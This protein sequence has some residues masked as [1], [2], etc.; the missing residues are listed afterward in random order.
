MAIDKEQTSSKRTQAK[1]PKFETTLMIPSLEDTQKVK[2]LN[3]YDYIKDNKIVIEEAKFSIA[4]ITRKFGVKKTE[5]VTYLK[6]VCDLS[7]KLGTNEVCEVLF[8]IKNKLEKEQISKKR[9]SV[10]DVAFQLALE[11]DRLKHIVINPIT[12]TPI[13]KAPTMNLEQDDV[14]I[15]KTENE[16][17]KVLPLVSIDTSKDSYV[18]VDENELIDENRHASLINQAIIRDDADYE[19]EEPKGEEIIEDLVI[20]LPET[21]KKKEKPFKKIILMS[22][23]ASIIVLGL[24]GTFMFITSGGDVKGKNN[25]PNNI[26]VVAPIPQ[27]QDNQGVAMNNTTLIAPDNSVKNDENVIVQKPLTIAPVQIPKPQEVVSST[28]NIETDL[29]VNNM[30]N[31]QQETPEQTNKKLDRLIEER[32]EKILNERAK[33]EEIKKPTL[34]NKVESNFQPQQIETEQP[35]KSFTIED[36][37]IQSIKDFGNIME[38]IK[39]TDGKALI[40]KGVEIVE[41]D[42]LGNIQIQ[43]IIPNVSV[44]IWDLKENYPFVYMMNK[45]ARK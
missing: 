3:M 1:K 9:K 44:R 6:S 34:V 19:K 5:V 14:P 11:D 40:Y 30:N 16:K 7:Q 45:K 20:K 24:V 13:E 27:A 28:K 23:F 36:I 8:H 32:L 38:E 42:T 22:G 39:F 37:K 43:R 17:T 29:S 33:S 35:Q 10:D 2:I 21:E 26:Q 12:E 25:N 18:P 15:L 41:G 31:I 4:P